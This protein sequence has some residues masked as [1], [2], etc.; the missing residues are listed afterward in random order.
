MITSDPCPHPHLPRR[1]APGQLTRITTLPRPC[2]YNRGFSFYPL[3]VFCDHGAQGIGEPLALPPRRV[4]PGP[5]TLPTNI[6][7]AALA[8]TTTTSGGGEGTTTGDAGDVDGRREVLVRTDSAGLTHAFLSSVTEQG[9]SYSV[10]LGCTPASRTLSPPYPRPRAHRP[11]T[12]TA[13]SATGPGWW[14]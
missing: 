12:P 11:T 3:A 6:T 14:S 2:T 4:T 13:T 5:T 9:V 10:G 1:V 8:R 7:A